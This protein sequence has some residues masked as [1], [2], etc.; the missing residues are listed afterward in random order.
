MSKRISDDSKALLE[1][2]HGQK[3]LPPI[4]K[5]I[6]KEELKI[7]EYI[8][9]MVGFA[10]NRQMAER[11]S[12]KLGKKVSG[13]RIH[14]IKQRMLQER[15]SEFAKMTSFD[16]AVE[17]RE[18]YRRIKDQAH[19]M[20]LEAELIPDQKESTDM[21]IKAGK[22]LLQAR[23]AEDRMY[24]MI[25]LHQERMVLEHINV[26]ETEEWKAIQNGFLA[27]LTHVLTCPQC[28]FKGFNPDDY[29]EFMDHLAQ[30]PHYVDQFVSYHARRRD[31][32]RK[33]EREEY[34]D[35]DAIEVE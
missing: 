19:Q 10:T 4:R 23:E 7:R 18:E 34:T 1:K 2:A 16:A 9:Q 22:L 26:M 31:K 30:D 24:K 25:G 8:E 15:K 35:A 28:G 21:K 13:K 6:S 27:Y 5:R 12:K 17:A 33:K 20:L 14:D 3:Y 11:I 32:I 29:F